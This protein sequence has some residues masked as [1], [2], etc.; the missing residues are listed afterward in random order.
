MN[1]RTTGGFA[2][3]VQTALTESGFQ[4]VHGFEV[5]ARLAEPFR[6]AR[7]RNSSFDGINLDEIVLGHE[8]SF[9]HVRT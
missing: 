8:L 2:D 4:D 9:W 7:G 5:R 1:I 3:G 6:Q